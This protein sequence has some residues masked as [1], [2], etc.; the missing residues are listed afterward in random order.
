MNINDHVYIVT[1]SS[2]GLGKSLITELEK[3]NLKTIGIDKVNADTTNLQ[4]DLNNVSIDD[5]T[6]IRDKIGE[7]TIKSIIHCAAVQKN[8]KKDFENINKLFDEVFTVNVKSI[9]LLATLLE[10]SFKNDSSVCIISSVHSEATT[11]NNTLYAAS[12]AAIR[13]LVNGLTV[14]NKDKFSTFEIVLGAMDSP[15]LLNSIS[16]DELPKLESQLPS[17]KILNTSEITK[18]I[19]DLVNKHSSILH[20]STIKI[21]NGVLSRLFTN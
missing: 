13:G 4:I 10:E 12:K 8:P 7:S 9:Y 19:V 14:S 18:L 16:E 21:D 2:S 15:M 6:Q 17:K 1:G 20:G 5:L 3:L 11:E